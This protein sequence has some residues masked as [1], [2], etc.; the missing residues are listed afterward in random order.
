[1]ISDY[2]IR[3]RWKPLVISADCTLRYDVIPVG[4]EYERKEK[5]DMHRRAGTA[6]DLSSQ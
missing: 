4:V 6:F 5:G 1:M 3:K 2:L